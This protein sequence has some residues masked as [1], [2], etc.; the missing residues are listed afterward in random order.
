MIWALINDLGQRVMTLNKR[1]QRRQ[2]RRCLATLALP[3]GSKALDFGCGTGLFANTFAGA[4]LTYHG[5][6]ID[7]RVVSYAERMHP[8]PVFTSTREEVARH[9][10]FDLV[11]ANCCFH[12]IS[13]DTLA[14]ELEWVKANLADRGTF[15]LIDLVVRPEDGSWLRRA[16][17]TLERGIFLRRAE[18]YVAIVA[19]H[20][21]VKRVDADRSHMLSV[22]RNPVYNDI[23]LVECEK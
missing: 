1:E 16:Y 19:R 22:P 8:G 15:L 18:E 10:P 21:T 17:R 2:L 20:L 7:S 5:Y 3:P 6:D 23:V 12:H 13:D 11:V 9:G 14:A 4:G